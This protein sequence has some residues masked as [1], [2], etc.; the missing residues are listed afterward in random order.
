M[1]KILA[2]IMLSLGF[3][4][5]SYAQQQIEIT[6]GWVRGTPPGT[7]ITAMYMNVENKGEQED[8][9]S[10]VSSKISKSAEIH[11][12]SVDDK[13]VAKM[14]MVES[15]AIPAGE[16][17][18]FKPGGMHIMLIDLE[19]PLKSGDEVEIELVFEKA[20]NIKVQ[21]EVVGVGEKRSGQ[22]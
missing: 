13:G 7:T 12:T 3:V 4:S 9:L 1:I 15:V 16:A 14:E 19:E 5:F 22:K 2:V 20:G 21:A 17:V 11:Q 18:Q 6:E 8:V 10:S